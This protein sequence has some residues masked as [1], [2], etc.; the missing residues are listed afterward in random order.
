MSTLNT[1]KIKKQ[2]FW[3]QTNIFPRKKEKKNNNLIMMEIWDNYYQELNKRLNRASA[4]PRYSR[5]KYR[6]REYYLIFIDKLKK[7]S[8]RFLMKCLF[9]QVIQEYFHT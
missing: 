4:V 1:Y 7:W 6:D 2:M 5:K 8:L 3:I 9:G